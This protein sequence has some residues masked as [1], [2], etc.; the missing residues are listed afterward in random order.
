MQR[1]VKPWTQLVTPIPSS[2]LPEDGLTQ[3]TGTVSLSTDHK[4]ASFTPTSLTTSP[5]YTATIKGGTSGVKDKAGNFLG[6]DHVWKF[7][8]NVPVITLNFPDFTWGQEGT[9]SGIATNSHTEDKI[10]IT[11]DGMLLLKQLRLFLEES[12]QHP[13]YTMF[14]HLP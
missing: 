2:C 11:G 12:L 9:A 1:S 8:T 6:A 3:V 10:S 14:K 5:G 7:T 4:I 13:T